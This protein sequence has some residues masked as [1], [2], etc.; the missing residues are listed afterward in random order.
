MRV[1]PHSEGRGAGR[2][3]HKQQDLQAPG[4][5]VLQTAPSSCPAILSFTPT[6]E[7]PA[8][9]QGGILLRDKRTHAGPLTRDSLLP[10]SYLLTHPSIPNSSITSPRELSR[11]VQ[12]NNKRTNLKKAG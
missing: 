11:H 4:L 7:P 6:A 10:L 8:F 9:L 1:A 2:H 12:S 5:C 3:E